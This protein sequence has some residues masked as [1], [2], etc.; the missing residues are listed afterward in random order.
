MSIEQ[1][2]AAEP[3]YQEFLATYLVQILNDLG[4]DPDGR[5]MTDHQRDQLVES[6]IKDR[7]RQIA[8]AKLHAQTVTRMRRDLVPA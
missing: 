8:N 4:E 5:Q 1:I 7:L 2:F 6:M 3:E